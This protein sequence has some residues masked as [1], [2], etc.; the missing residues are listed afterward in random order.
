[1]AIS[2]KLQDGS[3]TVTRKVSDLQRHYKDL[4][5][6]TQHGKDVLLSRNGEHVA[7]LIDIARYVETQNRATRCEELAQVV[8]QLQARLTLALAGGPSLEEAR[9]ES[10]SWTAEELIAKLRSERIKR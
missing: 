5:E 7:A 8:E 2:L 4:L 3:E 1:M 6:E 10:E 9:K